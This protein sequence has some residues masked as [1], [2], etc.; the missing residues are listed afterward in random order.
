LKFDDTERRKFFEL[1]H[2]IVCPVCKCLRCKK[3]GQ[4]CKEKRLDF[5]KK[6]LPFWA[7]NNP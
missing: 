4:C 2:R 3:F 7:T 1:F 6:C 5:K